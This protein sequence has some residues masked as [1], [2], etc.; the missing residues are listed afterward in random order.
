MTTPERSIKE[1]EELA[2]EYAR[3]VYLV[4]EEN[5]DPADEERALNN[6]LR[7]FTTERQGHADEMRD[8]KQSHK[9][10]VELLQAERKRRE[11]VFKHL[12]WCPQCGDALEQ[13][14]TKNDYSC[15]WCG[16]AHYELTQ[17]NNTK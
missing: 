11:E 5:H 16:G 9:Q 14:G 10:L 4:S 7:A 15:L 13:N 8:V 17:P 6:V 2:K 1:I 12:A 3:Q